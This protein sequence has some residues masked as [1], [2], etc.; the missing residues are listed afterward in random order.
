MQE[1][2]Q[3]EQEQ[4]VQREV[5]QEGQREVQQEGQREVQQEVQEEA[6]AG[7]QVL[8]WADLS[9]QECWL[10]KHRRPQR[11]PLSSVWKTSSSRRSSSAAW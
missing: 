8:P 6:Q 11:Q 3:Q 7:A 1:V 10:W 9:Q 4:G 5:Q 2:D